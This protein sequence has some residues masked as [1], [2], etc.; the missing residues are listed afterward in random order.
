MREEG[1]TEAG[2]GDGLDLQVAPYYANSLRT[3][4]G[5]D[6]KTSF[7]LWDATLSPEARLGYRY[8]FVGVAGEA[9]GGIRLHRRPHRAQQQLHLHRARSRHRQRAGGLQ[10]AAG[11]H[12][13]V[14]YDYRGINSRPSAPHSA[15]TARHTIRPRQPLDPASGTITLLGRI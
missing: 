8:D 3:F 7:S 5:V 2:G 4:L 11:R 14:W 10:P 12:R 13:N 15:R 9:E 1:Y 6:V